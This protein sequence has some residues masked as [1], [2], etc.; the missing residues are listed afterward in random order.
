MGKYDFSKG[1][2][3]ANPQYD[4]SKYDE[5]LAKLGN[6]NAPNI[7]PKKSIPELEPAFKDLGRL[8]VDTGLLLSAQLDKFVESRNTRY[9]T[10]KLYRIIRDST[11]CK[12]R[13]LHYFPI[14]KEK[15][16]EEEWCGWHN[17]HGTL[18]GLTSA[19]YVGRDGQEVAFKEEEGGLF[20]RSRDGSDYKASIPAD[21]LAFQIGETAQVHSGGL[22]RA[23]PH[24]VVRS[25]KLVGSGVS[26]NTLAVFM[27]PEWNESMQIPDNVKYED[28]LEKK[29]FNINIPRL[30]QRWQREDNFFNFSQKTFKFFN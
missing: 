17:D 6:I 11:G 16:L 4:E 1:S 20:V 15:E 9:E 3:Y 25:K 23:T 10:G 5:E 7:W 12:G 21:C 24:C 18:T 26:R 8:I 22:L 13:L 19:L 29:S 28:V 30:E 2:F 27:Q 14:E